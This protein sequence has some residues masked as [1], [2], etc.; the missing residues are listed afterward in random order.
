[1]LTWTDIESYDKGGRKPLNHKTFGSILD[2][3]PM[4]TKYNIKL[5]LGMYAKYLI[6]KYFVIRTT[7]T[8]INIDIILYIYRYLYNMNILVK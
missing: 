5:K 8:L 7:T 1:M 6:Y 3:P 4:D 2:R